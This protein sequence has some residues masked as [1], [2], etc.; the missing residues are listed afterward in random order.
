MRRCEIALAWA[1]IPTLGNSNHRRLV[2]FSIFF[3][4][5]LDLAASDGYGAL[6]RWMSRLSAAASPARVELQDPQFP[7]RTLL[8]PNDPTEKD[9]RNLLPHL[10]AATVWRGRDLEQ[11]RDDGSLDQAEQWY[12]RAFN[13]AGAPPSTRCE[14]AC[15]LV[16]M[17]ER[18]DSPETRHRAE[19]WYQR[20]A[21]SP[22]RA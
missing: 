15:R 7:H 17:L 4:K 3:A 20:A 9:Y 16:V 5:F 13:L 2:S 12:E 19:L 14:A 22:D 18:R 1:S 10:A 6:K 8:F 11:R 21:T